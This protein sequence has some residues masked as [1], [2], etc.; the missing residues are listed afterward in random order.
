MTPRIPFLALCVVL[1]LSASAAQ[2]PRNEVSLDAGWTD[3]AALGGARAVGASY[4]HFWTR[5]IA[6][7]IGTFATSGRIRFKDVHATAEVHALRERLLSPWAAFGIAQVS[8]DEP[9]HGDAQLTTIAGA[10]VDVKI[11]RSLAIGAQVHYS[12]Y[13]IDPRARF[14]LRVNP[15]TLAVAARWR[16]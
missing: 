10:G 7:Q 14:A 5:A 15:T 2:L 16:F 6:T 11:T 1:S 8:L 13:V 12:Y 3:F 4:S 9:Q